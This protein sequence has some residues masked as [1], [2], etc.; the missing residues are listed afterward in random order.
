MPVYKPKTPSLVDIS[1]VDM[2]PYPRKIGFSTDK[3]R[4]KISKQTMGDPLIDYKVQSEAL[5]IKP[6]LPGQ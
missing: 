1:K 3:S 2:S 5:Y 4:Y 6:P